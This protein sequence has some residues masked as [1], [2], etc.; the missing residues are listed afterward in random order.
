MNHGNLRRSLR[1][2][3][4]RGFWCSRSSRRVRPRAEPR[5]L[6]DPPAGAPAHPDDSPAPSGGYSALEARPPAGAALPDTANRQRRNSMRRVFAS[7]LLALYAAS[8]FGLEVVARVVA[9]RRLH[10]GQLGSFFRTGLQLRNGGSS[11][12]TG[13]LRVPSPPAARRGRRSRRCR[14]RSSPTRPSRGRRRRRDGDRRPRLA[15]P[16]AAAV[17]VVAGDR[18]A[19]LQRRGRRRNRGFTEDAVDPAQRGSG[20]P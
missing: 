15:R 12:L 18:L 20:A 1:R 7:V 6:S 13:R 5:H 9:G 3:G 17:L 4:P 19:R 11:A 10:A 14:S 2:G 8:A 16:D